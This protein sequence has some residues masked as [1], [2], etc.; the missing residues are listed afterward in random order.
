MQWLGH[1]RS[2]ERNLGINRMNKN[3]FLKNVSKPK[4]CT[5]KA[6]LR[7]TFLVSSVHVTKSEWSQINNWIS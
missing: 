4:E 5:V 3:S 6:V 1:W 2:Q 7:I